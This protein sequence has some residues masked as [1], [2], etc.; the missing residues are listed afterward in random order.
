ME[1]PGI[2]DG[3]TGFTCKHSEKF[4]MALVEGGFVI[5]ENSHGADGVIVS[6]QG[7]AAETATLADRLDAKLFDFIDIVLADQDRLPRSNEVLGEVVSGG[8]RAPGDAIA[9]ED[10]Q[11]KAKF[12]AQR[13]KLGDVEI[14]DVEEAAQFFPDFF[15]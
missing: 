7:N 3:D 4:E 13:I 11:I 9:A 14:F 15:G 10:F 1:K 2:F 5:G 6:H 8:T 12:V